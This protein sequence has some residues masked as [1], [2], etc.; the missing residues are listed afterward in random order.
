MIRKRDRFGPLGHLAV[1]L[2]IR[3]L[4]PSGDHHEN[5]VASEAKIYALNNDERPERYPIEFDALPLQ[6]SIAIRIDVAI[7]FFATPLDLGH[8]SSEVSSQK[9]K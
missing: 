7:R 9:T 3:H 6:L 4:L 2:K 8:G 5:G 1:V